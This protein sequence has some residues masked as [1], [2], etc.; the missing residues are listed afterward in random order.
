MLELVNNERPLREGDG[1]R[2][3]FTRLCFCEVKVRQ[4]EA[5]ER[6]NRRSRR[7]EG[8]RGR[9]EWA[10]EWA[11]VVWSRGQQDWGVVLMLVCSEV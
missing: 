4:T 9:S 2:K 6:A 8:S 5:E 1:T 10:V 7:V 3:R 11:T